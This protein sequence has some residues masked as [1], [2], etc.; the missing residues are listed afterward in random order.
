MDNI[1]GIELPSDA[2]P[3]VSGKQYVICKTRGGT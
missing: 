1:Y 2:L 3:A